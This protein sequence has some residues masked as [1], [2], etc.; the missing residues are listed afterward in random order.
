MN[1][2]LLK[3]KIKEGLFNHFPVEE[4]NSCFAYGSAVIPQIGNKGKMTDLFFICNDIKIF[5]EKNM[6]MN[7]SHYS[8]VS[9]IG[10]LNSLVKLNKFG[11]GVYYNPSVKIK[12]FGE[13]MLIKYGTVSLSDFVLHLRKWDNLFLAGRFHKPVLSVISQ[14]DEV[15]NA[16]KFN[17]ERAVI[18]YNL[19]YFVC[20]KK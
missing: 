13:E 6:K 17:R 14:N 20:F 8:S 2:I 11:S 12:S 15:E 3:S 10:K 7:E 4:I 9:K 5:H 16:I 18:I 19:V 1:N